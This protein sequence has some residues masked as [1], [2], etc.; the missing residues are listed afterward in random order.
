LAVSADPRARIT[1]ISR[2]LQALDSAAAQRHFELPSEAPLIKSTVSLCP[3]CTTHTPG[4]IF[5]RDGR[6]LLRGKCDRHG[7]SEGVLENDVRYYFISTKDRVGRVYDETRRFHIPEFSLPGQDS[8]CEGGSCDSTDQMANKS[9]TILVEVTNACNLSCT[10]CYSDARGDRIVPRERLAREIDELARK[11]GGLDS[12]QLTGGEALLHPEFFPLLAELHANPLIKK[13]YLP[14]N[15]IRLANPQIAQKLAPFR[16]K[17]LVL[18][19]FDGVR[20]ASD[21]ALRQA[22]PGRVRRRVVENMAQLGVFMQLTMTLTQGVNEDQVGAVIDFA[23]RHEHVKV[24]ALQPATYSGRYDL[25][26]DALTRLTLSDMIKAVARQSQLRVTEAD[27]VPIPCSHPNCGWI[28]LFVRR[29][30]ITHN[31]VRH[32][33]LPKV[34]DAV[35]YK[36][37][38][39]TSELRAAVGSR[40][41]SRFKRLVGSALK[42]FVRSQDM[43]TIAIKPFMDRYSYDQDRIANCCHHLMGT[44]GV[45]TSFCEYNAILRQ[46]DSW[47]K[48]PKLAD[49]AV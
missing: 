7:F 10:V 28:T 25:V 18:L 36:T 31:V 12:V 33:D 15:G 14:T 6:V 27:F 8:C 41:S 4:A 5:E 13:L 46:K 34:L 38:L 45:P 24:V 49:S 11:K 40:V 32:V 23:A 48:F 16:D 26:P 30:G 37:Q 20:D 1:A 21:R 42:G 9:C 35:S 22:T 47:E 29:F 43:F 2:Q 3:E 39:S 19:Q 44:D 17:L